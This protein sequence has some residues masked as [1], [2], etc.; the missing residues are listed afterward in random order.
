[1]YHYFRFQN[2]F[3]QYCK[4]NNLSVVFRF[5][6]QVSIGDE[7]LTMENGHVTTT[8]VVNVTNMIMKGNFKLDFINFLMVYIMI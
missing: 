8:K 5:A 4:K 6:N 2:D 1:M 3:E 7:V